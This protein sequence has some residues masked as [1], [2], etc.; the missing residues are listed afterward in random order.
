MSDAVDLAVESKIADLQRIIDEERAKFPAER[1]ELQDLRTQVEV[2]NRRIGQ[3][4]ANIDTPLMRKAKM[5]MAI[6]VRQRALQG[7]ARLRP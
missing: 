7:V 3:I 6:S 2:L 4:K 1:A 5:E